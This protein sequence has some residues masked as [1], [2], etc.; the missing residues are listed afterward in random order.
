MRGKFITFEGAD[1]CGKSTQRDLLKEYLENSDSKFDQ[2]NLRMT[3]AHELIHAYRAKYQNTEASNDYYHEKL[4]DDC[5]FEKE[6]FNQFEQEFYD[7]FDIDEIYDKVKHPNEKDMFKFLK[8]MISEK[9]ITSKYR[10]KIES[11]F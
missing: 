1:G 9:L 6:I 5:Y 2:L 10:I 7:K 8:V 11:I 3:L 4:D